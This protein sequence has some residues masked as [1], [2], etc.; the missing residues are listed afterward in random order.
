MLSAIDAGEMES[1]HADVSRKLSPRSPDIFPD[2]IHYTIMRVERQGLKQPQQAQ[3]FGAFEHT[4]LHF[5]SGQPHPTSGCRSLNVRVALS[6][7]ATRSQKVISTYCIQEAFTSPSM[8]NTNLGSAAWV[9][10]LEEVCDT[11]FPLRHTSPTC[12]TLNVVESTVQIRV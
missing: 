9:W 10:T 3:S 12:V 7:V 8:F 11:S 4:S 2:S 1:T 5:F 6:D